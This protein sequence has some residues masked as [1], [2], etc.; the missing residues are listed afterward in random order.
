MT[1][2]V[3]KLY[4]DKST[5]RMKNDLYS[6]PVATLFEFCILLSLL[7]YYWTL[8]SWTGQKRGLNFE[9]SKK[10]TLLFVR[11]AFLNFFTRSHYNAIRNVPVT[12]VEKE[13]EQKKSFSRLNQYKHWE[14]FVSWCRS[15]VLKNRPSTKCE[16]V[17]FIIYLSKTSCSVQ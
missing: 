14:D 4:I 17:E 13:I 10:V 2:N 6:I 15:I 16:F 3:R 8:L 1:V 11:R 7:L 5:F 12:T 9:R